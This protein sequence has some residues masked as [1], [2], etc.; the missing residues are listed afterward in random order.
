VKSGK[1]FL[2]EEK[3]AK[4]VI[5]RIG[6]FTFEA[7][8]EE[9][10]KQ[11]LAEKRKHGLAIKRSVLD[12]I[13]EQPSFHTIAK[14]EGKN[15]KY[16]QRKFDRIR[17]NVNYAAMGQL[18]LAFGDYIKLLEAQER[19]GT[20]ESY[21][22]TLMNLLKFK[23]NLRFEDVS[24][25]FLY[26]YERWMLSRG[27]S[28]T[29]IGIYLRNLRSIFNMQIAENRILQACYPFGK[30]KY[31]IPTGANVKKALELSDIKKIYDY[32]PQLPNENELFARDIWLF[33][34]YSNGINTKDIAYLKYKN[35]DEDFI[36]IKREKTKFTTRSKPKN[37]LIP[38]NEDMNA[39]IER[40][41]NKD[42]DTDNHIF[43]ILKNGLS[44][45]RKQELVHCFTR[46]V[47]NWMKKI[48][49]N[50]GIKKKVVTMTYRHS[51]A[52]I[53]KRAGVSTDFIKEQLGH[54]DLQTTE[55]YLDSFE[56]NIKKKFSS[57]L[58][59]FKNIDFSQ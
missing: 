40:W 10:Y 3:R 51:Y 20:S 1:N 41:G 29:T 42:K 58:M 32:S 31:Q 28:L 11:K 22:N 7:F 43:P 37:I 49:E 17:S 27:K 48:A 33:G 36:I 54:N 8:R 2:E 25:T 26:E 59:A 46:M 21:F 55:N 6:T 35:I 14:N 23:N 19:I 30:R 15:K 18:A 57:N 50:V 34:Y 45:H 53:L 9:F 16:G 56:L 24:V 39:I 4:E 38:I 52:T 12:V 5:Q 44:A 47:N 13:A